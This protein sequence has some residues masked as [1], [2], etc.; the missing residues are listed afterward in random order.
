MVS[1]SESVEKIISRSR[2]LSEAISKGIINF[3]ALARY[4]KPE[5]EEMTHKKVSEAALVMAL[6][7][8]SNNIKPNYKSN[9]I[10]ETPPDMMVRSNLA[11]LTVANSTT[12]NEKYPLLLKLIDTQGKNFLTITEG[13]YESTIIANRDL[14]DEVVKILEGEIIVAEFNSLSSITIR[15]PKPSVHTPGIFYFFIK[16][17]AWEG[18]NIIEIVSAHLELTLIFDE[19]DVNKAFSILQS[20]FSPQV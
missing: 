17:L 6:N 18:I 3:S 13:V 2:Y 19:K 4:I 7:R 10:F 11:E 12:M 14:K 5:I 9:E 20:L 16:S 15:L 1:I 8:L